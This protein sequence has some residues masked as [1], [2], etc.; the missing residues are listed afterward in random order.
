M[1][2]RLLELVKLVLAERDL[3]RMLTIAVDGVIELCGAERGMILLF[4]PDGTLV[5]EVAR[6]LGQEEIEGPEFE[7]SRAILERVRAEGSSFWHPNVLDD[8]SAGP[9]ESALQ[10]MVL[11]VICQPISDMGRTLGVVYLDNRSVQGVFTEEHA[12]LVE[13][14]SELVS[15]AARNALER[16]HYTRHIG[17]LS[18]ELRA[19]YDFNAIVGRHPKMIEVL[20]LV[21]RVA[22][23]DATVLVHGESGTGKELIARAIHSNSRRRT[24]PFIPVNCGAL[25]E[26]L[27]ESELFGHVRGAFTGAFRDHRGWFERAEGGTLLL[28]EV[29]ELPPSLQ[30]KLLRVLENHEYSPVGSAQIRRATARIV[31]ATNRDLE[32]LVREGRMRQDFLY[33]LNVVEVR[34]PSLR[35]RRSD[36]PLLIRRLIDQHAGRREPK[37]LA[38]DAERLLLAYDYPGNVRELQNLLHRAVLLSEGD[39]IEVRHLPETLRRLQPSA[40]LEHGMD[41][42]ELPDLEGFREAKQRVVERFERAYLSGCLRT[43]RGNISQA[44]RMARMDYKNFYTKMQQHGIDPMRYRERDL[45]P[46]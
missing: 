32:T 45:G 2:E 12:R 40:D 3:D 1:F 34:L 17:L 29:G 44:A 36:L 42:E 37:Q 35:E 18:K 5:F 25:P 4:N 8:P 46:G 31:A 38:P 33:R 19:R 10:P 41:G 30:V 24:K 9:W 6:N 21:A 26:A 20:R 14:F 43:A 7:V 11:S 16:R 23:D 27:L 22:D 15:L 39:T 13:R 28:D